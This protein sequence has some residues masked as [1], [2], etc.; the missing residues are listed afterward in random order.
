MLVE[1]ALVANWGGLNSRGPLQSL[2][3]SE[4][5]LA[6]QLGL[7]VVAVP[8]LCLAALIEERWRTEA[9]LGER[10]AFEQVLSRMSAALVLASG[11]GIEEA[12]AIWLGK[13]AAFPKVDCA[14]LTGAAQTISRCSPRAGSRQARP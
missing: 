7:S 3:P 14:W 9:E 1:I 2:P 12:A 6:L 5:V 10:R 13:L 8:I 4:R 11:R